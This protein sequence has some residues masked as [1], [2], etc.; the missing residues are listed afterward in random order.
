MLSAVFVRNEVLLDFSN[1]GL[2]A[3]TLSDASLYSQVM[4]QLTSR[5]SSPKVSPGCSTALSFS[6]LLPGADLSATAACMQ[7]SEAASQGH[8]QLCT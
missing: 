7:C 2:D 6:K 1:I 8:P 3:A 4:H 5:H